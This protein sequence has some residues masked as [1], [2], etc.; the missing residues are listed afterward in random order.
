[1]ISPEKLYEVCK[2]H[3]SFDRDT[4]VAEGKHMRLTGVFD[5]FAELCQSFVDGKLSVG[6]KNVCNSSMAY[7]F[8]L[9][10]A[11]PTDRFKPQEKLVASRVSPPDVDVD[12]DYYRRDEV[13]DYL[14][15]TYGEDYTCNIG[16]YNTLKARATV[17]FV[18]KALDTGNNWIPGE[19]KPNRDL[20]AHADAMAKMCP[21]CDTV[22]EACEENKELA[23]ALKTKGDFLDICKEVNGRIS[24]AGKHPA[25]IIVST[26]KVEELT[27]LRV[28]KGAVC[29]QFDGPELED[30]G[31]LKFDILAL[32]T[33]SII[34]NTL[35]MVKENYGR[36]IDID[37]IEPNDQDV[38]KMLNM[39]YTKG[40]FQMEGRAITG[41]LT[42]IVV[43]NFEDLVATNAIFRPGP[44]GNDVNTLYCDY[45]HGRQAIRY[46]H[47]SMEQA[48]KTTYGLIVYQEQVM[49]ISKT[50]AGFTSSEA[51]KLR[52]GIG[53]KND[54]I[55]AELGEKFIAGCVL[56]DI[57]EIVAKKTWENIEKFGGYGFNRSHAACYAYLAYQTAYLKKYY[58]KEFMCCLLSA[59]TEDEK[60]AAYMTEAKGFGFSLYGPNVNHSKMSFTIEEEDG[61]IAFRAPLTFLKGVGAK[62][63]KGI[64]DNQPYTDMR[65]FVSRNNGREVNSKV[66][67]LL[68][69]G[70]AFSC[71]GGSLEGMKQQYEAVKKE[72]KNRKV[73]PKDYSPGTFFDF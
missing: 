66:V 70:N 71:F 39:G 63:V 8:G 37:N 62:A 69:E 47:P 14:V 16:T 15:Q 30:I 38:F 1:M 33:L 48:L 43:D 45:K 24:S 20:L 35:K 73:D 21:E 61:V 72:L 34:E 17:R 58:T 6:T 2:E 60:L 67:S 29:A 12:F 23:I 68:I 7:W 9:T 32:K 50:M 18:S 13:Y 11:P 54:K 49:N 41:L 59:S 25:G 53:K 36:D 64:I 22:E 31:L 27:P 5:G 56:N 10:S 55:I 51:D 26:R 19:T 42:D 40:I 28:A 52:K 65:D 44:L 46:E 57:P 4:F 3:P